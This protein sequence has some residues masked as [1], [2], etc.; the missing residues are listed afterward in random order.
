MVSK[1]LYSQSVVAKYYGGGEGG[2][3]Q[4]SVSW[5]K[6]KGNKQGIF[7]GYVVGGVWKASKLGS[8]NVWKLPI[9][10]RNVYS[11]GVKFD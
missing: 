2:Q 5:C 3:R 6:E 8:V 9:G 1:A 11:I 7:W 4:L 10:H